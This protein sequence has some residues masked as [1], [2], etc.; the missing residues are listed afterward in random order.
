MDDSK[1]TTHGSG[2]EIIEMDDS[3]ITTHGSGE[4]IV[5]MDDLKV[6]EIEVKVDLYPKLEGNSGE[7]ENEYTGQEPIIIQVCCNQL[8][9]K[10]PLIKS[11]F[12]EF[13]V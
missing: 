9:T 2:E 3:K 13:A 1:V 10:F 11:A 6:D 4:E 8:Y 7:N 12:S 5:E